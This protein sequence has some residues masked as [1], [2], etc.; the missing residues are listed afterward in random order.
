MRNDVEFLKNIATEILRYCA[1]RELE[2]EKTTAQFTVLNFPIEEKRIHVSANK[3]GATTKKSR[4][5]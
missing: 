4:K 5:K 2:R 1:K 3:F